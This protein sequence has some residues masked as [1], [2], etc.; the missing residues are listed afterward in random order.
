MQQLGSSLSLCFLFVFAC[1]TAA[2][3]SSFTVSAGN[4]RLPSDHSGASTQFTIN[5]VS[6]YTGR[7]TVHC[8]YS[9]GNTMAR[10][11]LCGNFTATTYKLAANQSVQGTLG[12]FPWGTIAPAA[13]TE[14]RSY[15]LVLAAL[16]AGLGL[17]RLRR[18]GL[19]GLGLLVLALAGVFTVTSCGGNSLSGTFPYTVTAV[20]LGTSATAYTTIQITVP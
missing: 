5:S 15:G 13:T 12:V 19:R 9:G 10:V 8:E 14:E 11:P 17:L 3:A 2:A 20:D 7:F 18:R 4:V 1:A 6:G 16:F